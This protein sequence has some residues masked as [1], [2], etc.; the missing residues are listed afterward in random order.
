M[1]ISFTITKSIVTSITRTITDGSGGGPIDPDA[2]YWTGEKF[3]NILAYPNTSIGP[4]DFS[5]LFVGGDIEVGGYALVGT[6]PT[7]TIFDTNT[8]ILTGT[9]GS[10]IDV[11]PG[12]S[13]TATGSINTVSTNVFTAYISDKTPVYDGEGNPVYD[14]AGNPIYTP[15]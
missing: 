8:G 7:G 12:L 6:W 4:Y 1:S 15:S 2:V 10:D 5:T 13:V 9:W 14:G 3:Q 11:F